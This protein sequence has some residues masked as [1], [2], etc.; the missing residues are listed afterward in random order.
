[1]GGKQ[2]HL[3]LTASGQQLRGKAV[4]AAAAAASPTGAAAGVGQCDWA[5]G[6]TNP[7][8]AC[9]PEEPSKA[10]AE[11]EAEE[12]EGARAGAGAPGRRGGGGPVSIAEAL[13]GRGAAMEA[14]LRAALGAE[15]LVLQALV[16]AT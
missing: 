4:A 9:L 2:L 12:A 1:M 5:G 8:A 16:P 3:H 14:G 6:N 13:F 15:A 10:E 11:A 7:W